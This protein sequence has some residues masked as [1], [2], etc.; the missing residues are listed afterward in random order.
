M[1]RLHIWHPPQSNSGRDALAKAI[2]NNLFV[3]HIN[4]CC[5]SPP[6]H[7]VAI[8]MGEFTTPLW[9][10]CPYGQ[11]CC[12]S[13]PPL[14]FCGHLYGLFHTPFAPQLSFWEILLLFFSSPSFCVHL[15]C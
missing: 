2:Y 9:H 5:Y 12:C 1:H 13:S 15:Y 4:V 10:S 6:L 3:S 11:V 7:S 14:Y 8:L